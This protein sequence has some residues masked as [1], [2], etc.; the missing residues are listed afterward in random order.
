[1][2]IS[3][4]FDG[5][6]EA[7]EAEDILNALRERGIKT[8]I[9]LTGT[10]IKNHP[11]L[12][13]TMVRDGHEIGN[14]TMTHPHLTAFAE[15]FRHTTLPDVTKKF[16]AGELSRTDEAFTKVTGRRMSPF[17]RAPYGEINSEIMAWAMEEG[18]IHIGWTADYTR[19][20]SLDTLD[21]VHDRSSR[22]YLTSSQIKDKV[23]NF[24]KG[25]NG[26]SGGI[27]LMHLGTGRDEDRASEVL[28]EML[29]GLMEMGY[30]FVRVSALLEGSE[31]MEPLLKEYQRLALRES[32]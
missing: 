30:R 10:F 21:W 15:D 26:L 22:F 11:G 12:V 28:E 25:R 7:T 14:H 31:K 1:M 2:D 9:F 3:I 29:D 23:L 17:W 24:G 16:L 19:R 20:E 6:S 5:G 27:I 18:Y 32:R 4:T 8:T 13:K